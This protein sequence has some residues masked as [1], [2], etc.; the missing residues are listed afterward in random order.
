MVCKLGRRLNIRQVALASAEVFLTRFLTRVLLKEVNL[1]LLA[2]TCV[3]V[4]CKSEE[5][6][7]HIRLIISGARNLWPEY[8]PHDVT[9]LAEFE[10]YLI[11]EM[12]LY[13]VLHHPYKSLLHMHQYLAENHLVHRLT[14]SDSDLQ[15]AWSVI[16]DSYVT[17]V[18]LLYPPHVIAV[19]CVYITLV[20]QRHARAGGDLS[21]MH[22]DDL[23]DMAAVSTG[24]SYA[25]DGDRAARLTE[26]INYSHMN[27][28]EIV[29]VVEDVLN[30]YAVWNRYNEAAVKKAI[31]D[32]LLGQ[33]GR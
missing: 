31:Q 28:E 22:M 33:G 12:D 15:H 6:P 18:H 17:D 10:F 32:M 24:D 2:T 1:Y 5:C 4:A 25:Y 21:S 23:A 16:N 19:A 14:L 29:D 9:K 11:E 20:L 27:L 30:L 7:Q 13:L 26:F 3:Y 8:I